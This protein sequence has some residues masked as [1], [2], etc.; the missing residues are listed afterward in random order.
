MALLRL[1]GR[2]GPQHVIQAGGQLGPHVAR[3]RRLLVQV[4]EEDGQLA[5]AF[6]RCP[7]REG[8]VED[9][10]QGV[11]VRA[12]VVLLAWTPST[13]RRAYSPQRRRLRHR[14]DIRRSS[15]HLVV[16]QD[17]QLVAEI[18]APLVPDESGVAEPATAA[19]A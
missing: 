13:K 19:E 3:P 1:L 8:L 18:D 5:L 12:A 10:R 4:R 16:R 11:D 17:D 6:E 14:I 7:S 15:R 9:A 2:P